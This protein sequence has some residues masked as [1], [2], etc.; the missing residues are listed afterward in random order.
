[1]A[2]LMDKNEE[3]Q[4]KESQDDIKKVYNHWKQTLFFLVKFIMPQAGEKNQTKIQ[5]LFKL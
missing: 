2:Q 5:S 3:A 1:M 4:S